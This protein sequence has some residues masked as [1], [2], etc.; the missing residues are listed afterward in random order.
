MTNVCEYAL[1]RE[2]PTVLEIAG[3]YI[4]VFQRD[5]E[6]ENSFAENHAKLFERLLRDKKIEGVAHVVPEW[7]LPVESGAQIVEY[8]GRRIRFSRTRLAILRC[9]LLAGGSV[10][11]EEI[12]MEGWG[13]P[14]DVDTMSDTFYQFNRFFAANDIPKFIRRRL[15]T[16]FFASESSVENSQET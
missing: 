6:Q 3:C 7:R 5:R 9:L 11:F 2:K 10:T 12:A 16:V 8:C 14:T 13:E 1:C 15:G 4:V